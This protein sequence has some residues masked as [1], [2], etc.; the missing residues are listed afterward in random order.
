MVM[1]IFPRHLCDICVLYLC[2][3]LGKA[4]LF[5][6]LFS[7][8]PEYSPAATAKDLFHSLITAQ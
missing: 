6:V 7:I 8:P 3:L 2:C 4:A 5:G 1:I